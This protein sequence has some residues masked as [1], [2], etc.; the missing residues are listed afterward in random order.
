MNVHWLR[1]ATVLFIASACSHRS[2]GVVDYRAAAE[3]INHTIRANH[4]RPAEL[5]NDEYRQL[6]ERVIR[7]GET[8]TSAEEFIS[9]FRGIWQRGPFS[10]VALLPAEEPAATRIA[11]LDTLRAGDGAVTLVWVGAAAIL[12]VNTMSGADTIERIE[13]AYDEIAARGAEKL[14]IDLRSNDGGA[15]AVMPLIGHL[16][17]K[18]IDVGVFV[19]GSW[20]KEHDEPPG[21]RDFLSATPWRGYSVRA[22]QAEMLS[23]PL[24]SYRIEAMQ[25]IFD[26][27]VYVLT[28]ARSL[29]AAEIA[30]DALKASGRATIVGEKTPGVVLSSKR[31]D[32]PGGFHLMV[33]IADYFSIENGRIEGVGVTPD[34]RVDADQAREVALGL[35]PRPG[36]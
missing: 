10:H 16:I 18:A 25:P 22:F 29:S 4:Y 27:P 9:G 8:A 2:D 24:T 3:L 6:E 19:T 34:I 31:F 23:R 14:V 7:L 15:F 21:R 35:S 17:P 5:D 28:S 36:E 30:A 26:G 33:P 20:Y 13:S 1:I 32:I 12:T 11:R